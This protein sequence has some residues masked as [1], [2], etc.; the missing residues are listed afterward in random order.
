MKWQIVFIS[1]L[2]N[3]DWIY[4]VKFYLYLMQFFLYGE[5]IFAFHLIF[6]KGCLVNCKTHYAILLHYFEYINRIPMRRRVSVG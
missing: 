3:G 5:R 6:Q 1:Y 2:G 4:Y